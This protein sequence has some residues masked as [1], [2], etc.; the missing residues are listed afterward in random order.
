MS[1]GN[2]TSLSAPRTEMRRSS[3]P[4]RRSPPK[5]A[6]TRHSSQPTIADIEEQLHREKGDAEKEHSEDKVR[7]GLPT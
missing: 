4:E 2:W 7:T 3:T 6:R 5:D 1:Q